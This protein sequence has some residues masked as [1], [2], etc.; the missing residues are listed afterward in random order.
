[1]TI[2]SPAVLAIFNRGMSA[3]S[4][5]DNVH[6]QDLQLSSIFTAEILLVTVS[7]HTH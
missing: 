4:F 6:A 1:M 5:T 3:F 7:R 2:M